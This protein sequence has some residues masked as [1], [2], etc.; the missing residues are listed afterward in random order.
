MWVTSGEESTNG[1]E[2]K[3]EPQVQ[4]QKCEELG[5]ATVLRGNHRIGAIKVLDGRWY[6]R[7]DMTWPVTIKTASALYDAKTLNISPA[8]A[9][10]T[11]PNPF[12]LNHTVELIIK[13]PGADE[14]VVVSARVVWSTRYGKEKKSAAFAMGV[15]FENMSDAD[16]ELIRDGMSRSQRQQQEK[17]RKRRKLS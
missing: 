2:S 17:K 9:S 13:V 4:K 7:M 12:S 3:T 11:C 1:L 6:I 14:P 15:R 8:G 5:R 16:G 10:I